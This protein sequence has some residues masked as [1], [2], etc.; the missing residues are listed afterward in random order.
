MIMKYVLASGSPRRRELIEKVLDNYEVITSEVDER[1]IEEEILNNNRDLE[2]YKLTVELT[3]TLS[4]EKALA[5]FNVLG[6]PEDTVI[7]GADTSVL[8]HDE[9]MGKPRD[10]EDAVRMLRKESTYPQHVITGVTLVSKNK[11]ISFFE[12]TEVI[13][14]KMDDE[15][16]K[17][18][19]AYVNTKEPYDKAGAYGIQDESDDMVL[20]Y[21][22]D[23]DN[24]M[25]LPTDRLKKELEVF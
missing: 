9:I 24:I 1:L 19:Q 5:V 16:E 13:F 8:C 15:Q 4:K 25:G 20:K 14:K 10:K 2:M 12:S 6:C 7:I 21:N 11:V 3:E 17:R 18:I 23:Y 22:G